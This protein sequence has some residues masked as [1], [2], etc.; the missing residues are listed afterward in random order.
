VGLVAS[1][2]AWS[3]ALGLILGNALP[4]SAQVLAAATGAALIALGIRDALRAYFRPVADLVPVAA[5]SVRAGAEGHVWIPIPEGGVGAV[6][7]S[8]AGRRITRPARGAAQ[9][10]LPRLAPIHVVAVHGGTVLVSASLGASSEPLD[11]GPP[12]RKAS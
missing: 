8:L 1:A 4:L 12:R 3:G 9:E 6:V 11:L 7:L 10:A 2:S 5:Q